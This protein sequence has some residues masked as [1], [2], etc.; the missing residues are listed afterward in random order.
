[1]ID[2]KYR[3]LETLDDSD[4][5]AVF[6][7][8]HIRI[9]RRVVVK[10][11]H[12][13]AASDPA[14]LRRFVSEAEAAGQ[15]RHPNIVESIDM[16][17][18][19]HGD[20]FVVFE[21]L[22]GSRL[23]EEIRRLGK[24]PPRRAVHIARQIA[25]ALDAAHNAGLVHACLESSNVFLIDANDDPDFVKVLG[26]GKMGD[27]QR[28]RKRTSPT[29]APEQI[30]DSSTVDRRCDVWAIGVLLYEMLTG[31]SPFPTDVGDATL[32]R[33]IVRAE[34]APFTDSKIPPELAAVVMRCLAKNPNERWQDMAEVDTELSLFD[35]RAL[36]TD[37]SSAI[38]PIPEPPSTPVRDRR[39]SSPIAALA[40][41]A[42]PS[43]QQMAARSLTPTDPGAGEMSPLLMA[44]PRRSVVPIAA[45][46]IALAAAGGGAWFAFGRD[47]G[48][49]ATQ[50][51]A[52]APA[53]AATA[54]AAMAP[55]A[56]LSPA[57]MTVERPATVSLS[58][59]T[60][61]PR[62]RVT[63]RRRVMPAP[64]AIEVAS[65]DVVELLEVSAP[66]HKTMRYWLTIDRAT[67]LRA[68][69]VPGEGLLE[70][71]EMQTLVALGEAQEETPRPKQAEAHEPKKAKVERRK[72]GRA[73]D[74]P[75]VADAT[76]PAPAPEAP[77]T[78][79]PEADLFATRQ[80]PGSMTP[81]PAPAAAPA[82]APKAAVA[83]P[84]PAPAKPATI[85]QVQPAFLTAK[86]IA[87]NSD[88]LPDNAT[89]QAMRHEGRA[90]AV[91]RF[92]VCVDTAGKV[93][94]VKKL[95][96]SGYA[97]YDARIE[98]ELR[99]WKFSPIAINGAATPVCSA[100]AISYAQ[101]S[102]GTQQ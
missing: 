46:V 20:P 39:P 36:I 82:A 85:K 45:I 1:M 4:Q 14:R 78:Q 19:D 33:E 42:R 60:T 8:E 61:A 58:V 69:L 64:A 92:Q 57:T 27:G 22:Q 73:D 83:V 102:V 100:I 74:A 80:S 44:P 77:T 79:E 96:S 32:R 98:K 49:A 90:K 43:T 72:T 21:F 65:S 25:A 7:A 31:R 101:Q 84:K 95:G 16:G 29:M 52:A 76:D 53:A 12:S 9:G 97:A 91:G 47:S 3:I 66:G 67:Q 37:S 62:A 93:S 30:V 59:Q 18:P 51:T 75:A 24:L 40:T 6:L 87:G 81:E 11:L 86:R 17:F 70:A 41:T 13:D 89:K 2:G 68:Q 26:L 94:S 48:S 88:I 28:P 10:V 56:A 5:R 63:F 71:S 55:A 15:L 35:L 99:A 34:I 50:P 38:P 54:P 23:G